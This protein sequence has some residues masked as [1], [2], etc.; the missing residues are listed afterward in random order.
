MRSHITSLRWIGAVLLAGALTAC[1]S[2]DPTTPTPQ[3]Q[4]LRIH[5]V[6]DVDIMN[7]SVLFPG[8]TPE[9]MA[10][11]I[12]F[13]DVAAGATT[14]YVDVPGGVYRYSA[15]EYMLDGTTITQPVI[16]WVGESPLPGQQFTYE[17]RLDP[18]AVQGNQMSLVNVITDL[19]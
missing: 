1:A 17:I 6:G 10:T 12:D 4:Q 9:S 15:Y 18:A 2:A 5:N 8:V 19:P 16:D 14:V 11:H 3:V 13:G 7:L